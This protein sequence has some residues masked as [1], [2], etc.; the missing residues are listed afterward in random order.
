MNWVFRKTGIW[1]RIYGDNAGRYEEVI[2]ALPAH[3]QK[4]MA[5]SRDCKRLIDPDACSGTSL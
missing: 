4:K 5:A 1:A 3:M 2:A